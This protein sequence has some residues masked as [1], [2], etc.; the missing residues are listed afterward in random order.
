MVLVAVRLA[1][2]GYVATLRESSVVLG[3]VLGWLV[4]GEQLGR[5]RTVSSVIVLAGLVALIMFR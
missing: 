1:P 3:A 4:L 5:R 2:V